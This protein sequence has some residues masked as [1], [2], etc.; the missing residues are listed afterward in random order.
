MVSVNKHVYTC[1]WAKDCACAFA[2]CDAACLLL[3]CLWVS[4]LLCVSE[5]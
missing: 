3:A 1:F 2:V 5:V 4:V